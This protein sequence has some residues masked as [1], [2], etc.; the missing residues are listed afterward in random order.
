VAQVK[1]AERDLLL[2]SLQLCTQK[3][4]TM[5]LILMSMNACLVN[6]VSL[7]LEPL[8]KSIRS[9]RILEMDNSV[10]HLMEVLKVDMN[11]PQVISV[12]PAQGSQQ[13]AVREPIDL[14]PEVR[15]RPLA[16]FAQLVA[17][18][19]ELAVRSASSAAV[20]QQ[21]MQTAQHVNASVPSVPGNPLRMPVYANK[22]IS[23]TKL[24]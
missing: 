5:E 20:V 10:A 23:R 12:Q 9:A 4:V 21:T 15:V 2:S 22:D 3:I 14:K 1:Y 24:Q 19:Q 6:Q 7:A 16:S 18:H 17:Q 8:H 13:P 11:A